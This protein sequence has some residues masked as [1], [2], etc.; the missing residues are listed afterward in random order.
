MFDKAGEEL[1]FT[2]KNAKKEPLN[3]LVINHYT[4]DSMPLH[5]NLKVCYGA[6]GVE[7][8]K[9]MKDRYRLDIK[10]VTKV[11]TLEM[12]FLRPRIS[13]T[14]CTSPSV[15]APTSPVTSVPSSQTKS[16][17]R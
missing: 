3:T 17:V 16:I 5:P 14:P 1:V 6:I 13:T 15:S 9:Q 4:A 2:E 11:A 8:H 10:R 12:S 7:F